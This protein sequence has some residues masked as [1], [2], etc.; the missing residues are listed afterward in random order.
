MKS[1][2]DENKFIENEITVIDPE[3]LT[4]KENNTFKILMYGFTIDEEEIPL[5]CDIESVEPRILGDTEK[6]YILLFRFKNPVRNDIYVHYTVNFVFDDDRETFIKAY[7]Y[8]KE[9]ITVEHILLDF[10]CINKFNP[11][12]EIGFFYD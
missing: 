1:L 7:N 3:I 11:F 5:L 12:Y 9:L 4:V 2:N 10:Y 6:Q 8:I